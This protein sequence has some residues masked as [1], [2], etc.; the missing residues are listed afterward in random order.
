MKTRERN[1]LLGILTLPSVFSAQAQTETRLPIISKV[2]VK[3]SMV[4]HYNHLAE[5]IN[6]Y[7]NS[8]DPKGNNNY[9]VPHLVYEPV[10]TL[11]NPHNTTLTLPKC[12]VRIANPPVG[13]KFRKNQEY[14]RAEWNSGGPFLGLGRFQTAN[15]S[16]PDVQK[17]ITLLLRTSSN[18]AS[19]PNGSIVLQPGQAIPFSTWVEPSWTWGLET[20]NAGSRS[21]FDFSAANDRTNKDAR[22]NNL[23]GVETPQGYAYGPNS[24]AND[25]RA[26]F[27]TDG[28]SVSTGRPAITRYPFE[29]GSWG[30]TSWVAMKLTD[31]LDVEA[32]GVDTVQNPTV[33]DFQVALMG[34]ILQNPVTD[35]LK[36]YSFSIEDLAQ[37]ATPDATTPSISRGF[38]ISDLLQTPN[39][40]TPGGKTPI[41]S[42][43]LVAR[44]SALQQKKFQADTQPPTNELYEARLEERFDFTT[45]PVLSGPSDF[46]QS[47]VMVTGAERVGNFLML[48]IAAPPFEGS[49]PYAK[50]MGGSNLDAPLTDDLTS[51]TLIRLGPEG[52]GIYKLTIPVPAGSEKYFVQIGY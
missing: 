43:V 23:F 7:N 8:G 35:T 5:R 49:L 42:F 52:A 28:L 41:A 47:G 32:K 51:Q 50:I 2:E 25:L 22:T 17:T 3:Y 10:V 27:Q 34:G 11:Y 44:S 16:N 13:F 18:S 4:S 31:F 29:T 39:D 37:P 36:S 24:Y 33:P 26:G 40:N 6:F 1:F 12:R 20:A 30:T 14:L 45:S 48:D 19:I 21:F 46:P 38:K 9:A 15:E